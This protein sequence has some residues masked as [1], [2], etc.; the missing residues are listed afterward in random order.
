MPEGV[1]VRGRGGGPQAAAVT[2]GVAAELLRL[3]G[4]LGAQPQSCQSPGAAGCRRQ[5]ARQQHLRLL[6]LLVA[7]LLLC[8]LKQL[9]VVG[10]SRLTRIAGQTGILAY[11]TIPPAGTCGTYSLTWRWFGGEKAGRRAASLVSEQ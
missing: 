3:H 6:F 2:L 10:V 11:G 8:L 1:G 9:G 5:R 7:L 4:G